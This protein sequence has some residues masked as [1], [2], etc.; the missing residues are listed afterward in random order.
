M[1]RRHALL[2]LATAGAGL[3]T[4]PKQSLAQPKTPKEMIV[5][6]WSLESI[7]DQAADGTKHYVWGDGVQ[8]MAIYTAGGHFSS[9][10]IAGNRDKGASKSPRQPVGQAIGYFG[11]YVVDDA[12]MTVALKITQCTF[13]GWD[14][15]ERVSKIAMLTDDEYRTEVAVVHDP[16]YGDVVPHTVYKRIG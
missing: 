10:V 14:G 16:V 9:Q 2:A 1:D 7:Y 12:A 15:V 3:A 6:A 4:L 13:P 11:T 5:G 8:G